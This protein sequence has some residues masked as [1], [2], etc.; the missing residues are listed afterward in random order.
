[1]EKASRVL[2][3]A[4]AGG[5]KNDCLRVAG[6]AKDNTIRPDVPITENPDDPLHWM[7]QEWCEEQAKAARDYAESL[8]GDLN[9]TA[10]HEK[11]LKYCRGNRNMY[12]EGKPPY[13]YAV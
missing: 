2:L 7:T 9:E 10:K 12:S 8:P 4:A 13:R 3:I 11:V 6:L 1:M 5:K